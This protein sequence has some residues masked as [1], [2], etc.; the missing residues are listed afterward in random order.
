MK[1]LY[2][3]ILAIA[4]LLSVL[5]ISAYAASEIVASGYCGAIWSSDMDGKN[6]TW[7][8]YSDGTMVFSGS[9]RM[10]DFN[11]GDPEWDE[12]DGPAIT[13]V[14]VEEGITNLGNSVF[15][16]F[17]KLVEVELPNSLTLINWWAFRECTS[18]KSI[19]IPSGVTEIGSESPFTGCSSLEEIRVDPDNA[20]FADVDGV[21]CN[22]DQTT[23]ICY[24]AGKT[25]SF[26]IPATIT[27]IEAS[28][29]SGAKH[30]T[31]VTIPDSV[32]AIGGHAFAYC[33]S[34]SRVRFQG[35]APQFKPYYGK[36]VIF[37]DLTATV[38]YPAN[39]PTWTEDVFRNAGGNI[40]WTSAACEHA[41]K[42]EVAAV[43]ADCAHAGN[44]KYY[45]CSCG[46]LFRADAVTPTTWEAVVI[47]AAG[48]TEVIEAAVAATCTED[49]LTEGKYCSVCNEVL[50]EQEVIAAHGHLFDE[51]T[52]T[53]EPT[54]D[55]MG[56]AECLC[57]NCGTIKTCAFLSGY[58]CDVGSCGKDMIWVFDSEGTLSISG[59]GT[60]EDYSYPSPAPWY[61]FP[62]KRVILS[63][64]IANIG[65]YAFYRCTDMAHITIPDTINRIEDFAFCGCKALEEIFLPE[66]V[67]YIGAYAFSEC[68]SLKNVT[69]PLG[70]SEIR[71]RT[72]E[73]CSG[74]ESIIIPENITKIGEGAFSGCS[75]LTGI[76]IP[77]GITQINWSTFA[78]CINLTTVTLPDG[79]TN[80]GDTA[81][82][83]CHSLTQINIPDSVR[84][85]GW[86]AFYFCKSLTNVTIPHGVTYIDED[87]FM[88]CFSLESITIPSSVTEI[89]WQ[90]FCG[91]SKMDVITFEGDPP[92]ISPGGF[93]G[94]TASAYYP[95][96][97]ITWTPDVLQDY[98]GTLMWVAVG[99]E[100]TEK[101]EVAAVPATCTN[102]GN[103]RYY[104]CSCGM[105]FKNDG[106]TLSTIADET[107]PALGHTEVIDTAVAATCTATGL[108]EGK[109]CSV[110]NTVLVN[111]EVI[112]AK[113]HDWSDWK[114]T[115]EPTADAEGE[116]ERKCAS[117][118]SAETKTLPKKESGTEPVK[119]GDVNGD[120]KLNA[121]DA[122]AILKKIVGKLE[123]PIE[124]FDLIADI[125]DD[126]KVNAKDATWV[127]K[128]IVG[129][130]TIE[131]PVYKTVTANALLIRD[132]A[133]SNY[134]RIGTYYKGDVV[135]IY[136]EVVVG[137]NTWGRTDRGWIS[138]HYV[139]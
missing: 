62:V 93:V 17:S 51:W 18:L 124:N 63:E 33:S 109:H 53:M 132:G 60:M 36:T 102:A 134:E 105:I 4:L 80:I 56:E 34:L 47:P 28:A 113:G 137:R 81:F 111:Q 43:P 135:P 67:S 40:T 129:K 104:V 12:C 6:V 78:A 37:P 5:P 22:K 30:L 126:G 114:T 96:N 20:A 10:D 61:E 38:Y 64:G 138:M 133:G 11:K 71:D 84:S 55:A 69:I 136:E 131:A 31:E 19:T 92:L 48:H 8:I 110:C 52:V 83:N 118:D 82:Y 73:F 121:K 107:L 35:N 23:L 16:N 70:L 101:T 117:C 3:L 45:V 65:E 90:A 75:S 125:N 87:A 103:R 44:R 88:N 2:A 86:S 112:P 100:H 50:A 41:E 24:P 68:S 76:V 95:A 120:G 115:K 66:D 122:T 58:I 57:A 25:G 15:S 7:T 128:Y 94:V 127:L 39:D 89:G 97:N 59:K 72:F 32:A 130:V 46:E 26:S 106:I 119:L 116:A 29:F 21:L 42:A 85:I 108:T 13:K 77:D 79:M 123:H 139:E 91:C 9:G 74:L 49:G 99:C 98:G 54:A 27:E 1:R 14:I